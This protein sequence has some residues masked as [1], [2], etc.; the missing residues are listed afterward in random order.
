MATFMVMKREVNIKLDLR[1]IGCEDGR[2]MR[3]GIS[4]VKAWVPGLHTAFVVTFICDS[5]LLTTHLAML[6]QQLV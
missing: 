1:K 3:S 4:G 5:E 2:W 6:H